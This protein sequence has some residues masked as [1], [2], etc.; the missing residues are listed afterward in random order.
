MV[1]SLAPASKFDAEQHIN[2]QLPCEACGLL[3]EGKS[4]QRYWPCR[5]LCD[6]PD[7]HFV[8]DPRDY[9]LASLNGAIVGIVH[10][11]P[12]GQPASNADIKACNQSGLRWFIY[13]VP[14]DQWLIIDPC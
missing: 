1:V 11:H 9:Y 2:Q 4:G 3:A 5:N 12:Q 7:L 8:L 13:Q 6:D 14:Q 10:S